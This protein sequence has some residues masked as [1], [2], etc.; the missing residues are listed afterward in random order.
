M[1]ARTSHDGNVVVVRERFIE[2]IAIGKL[3]RDDIKSILNEFGLAPIYSAHTCNVTFFAPW[4]AAPLL[5]SW[6]RLRDI[7][8]RAWGLHCLEMGLIQHGDLIPWPKSRAFTFG[9]WP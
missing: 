9:W 1:L 3:Q 5:A 7:T 6:L 4:W 8:I 2:R